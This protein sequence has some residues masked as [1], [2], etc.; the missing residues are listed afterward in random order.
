M[1]GIPVTADEINITCGDISRQ[2][3]QVKNRSLNEKAFL[4]QYTADALVAAFPGLSLDDANLLKSA[5]GEW[6]I[7]GDTIEANST[8]S[9]RLAGQGDV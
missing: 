1:A 8:F 9:A 5:A 6:Q 2:Y 4:D 7:I 3:Q